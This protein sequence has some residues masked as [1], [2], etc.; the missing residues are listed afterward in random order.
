MPV[1]SNSEAW[2]AVKSF[3]DREDFLAIYD[4]L[5]KTNIV[6]STT[7]VAPGYNEMTTWMDE[8]GIWGKLDS[9]EVSPADVAAELT[10]KANELKDEWLANHVK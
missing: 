3:T 9:R 2:A 7:S 4:H 8:N 10:Q 5:E 6:S 1:T